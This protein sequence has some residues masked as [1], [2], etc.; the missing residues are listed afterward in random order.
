MIGEPGV[1]VEDE[2]GSAKSVDE[3]GKEGLNDFSD[4]LG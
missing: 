3:V 1:E 4:I 2:G